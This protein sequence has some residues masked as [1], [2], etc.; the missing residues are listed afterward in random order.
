METLPIEVAS[1]E[2]H[3]EFTWLALAGLTD[4]DLRPGRLKDSL[5]QWTET[6]KLFRQGLS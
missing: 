4:T 3:L 5:L 6:G 2:A 1:R